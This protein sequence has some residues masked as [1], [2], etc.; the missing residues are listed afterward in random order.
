MHQE[1]IGGYSQRKNCNVDFRDLDRAQE[2]IASDP[3]LLEAPQII[4]EETVIEAKYEFG[5]A[6]EKETYPV[7]MNSMQE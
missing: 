5:P 3:L 7:D 1:G 4:G 6:T 2:V